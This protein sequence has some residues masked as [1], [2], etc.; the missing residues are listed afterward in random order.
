MTGRRRRP[1]PAGASGVAAG[2]WRLALLRQDGVA[3]FSATR[4]ALL[5]SFAPWFAVG[6]VFAILALC[7]GRPLEGL[8]TL[9]QLVCLVLAVPVMSHLLLR[10]WR[11]EAGWLRFATVCIWSQ[12]LPNLLALLLGLVADVA[13]S[14]GV[15]PHLAILLP[16]LVLI[17][18]A[19]RLYWLVARTALGLDRGR[20]LLLLLWMGAWVGAISLAPLLLGE[21]PQAPLAAPG[22]S[23]P[24]PA[25]QG[26]GSAA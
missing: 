24:G 22:V 25:A 5:A 26:S 20:T 23:A 6:I 2:L 13:L 17:A 19:L 21:R 4:E 8:S 7:V 14:I 10:V 12:W 1:V 9:L 18:Y 16:F 3:C 11:L 15:R